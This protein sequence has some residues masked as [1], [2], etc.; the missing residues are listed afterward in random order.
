M[1]PF[2]KYF[3]F[4][5]CTRY[6][7][8]RAKGLIDEIISRGHDSPNG[9]TGSMQ[10]M[11][12]PAGKAGLIIGKGGETIKQLQVCKMHQKALIPFQKV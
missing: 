2:Q 11:V 8:R 3:T 6:F 4:Y 10:E 12:I 1:K 9:Q 7:F 5:V